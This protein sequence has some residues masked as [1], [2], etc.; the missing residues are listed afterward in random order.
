MG[1][2]DCQN[3]TRFGAW[4]FHDCQ[5]FGRLRP[6]KWVTGVS[7]PLQM[8][9]LVGAHGTPTRNGRVT[10]AGILVPERLAC[11]GYPHI[12]IMVGYQRLGVG[13]LQRPTCVQSG[14]D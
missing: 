13:C 10:N 7:S 2:V 8:E 6:Y 12:P 1:Y 3:F 14:N 9:L 4:R 11:W 5:K